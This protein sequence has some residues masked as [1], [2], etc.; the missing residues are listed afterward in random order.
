M[1]YRDLA[2]NLKIEQSQLDFLLDY[3]RYGFTDSSQMLAIA[4]SRLQ[5]ELESQQ[6]IESADLYAEVYKEDQDLQNLTAASNRN[7]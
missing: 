6:L 3:Q 5:S 1:T 4:L 7:T 2:K